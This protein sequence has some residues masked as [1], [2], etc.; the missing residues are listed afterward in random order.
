MEQIITVIKDGKKTTRIGGNAV[1]CLKKIK[2]NHQTSMFETFTKDV[3][4]KV[5]MT[6]DRRE[7]IV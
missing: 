2:L 4:R 6:K 1:N 5:L 7:P 3:I